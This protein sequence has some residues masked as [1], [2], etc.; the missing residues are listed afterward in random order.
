M[1]GGMPELLGAEDLPG[2]A[3]ALEADAIESRLRWIRRSLSQAQGLALRPVISRDPL[4]LATPLW[5]RLQRTQVGLG[6]GRIQQGWI[7]SED[8]R[9]ILLTAIPRFPASDRKR[10]ERMIQAVL[11]AAREVEA[12]FSASR[13]QVS[14]T[15]AHRMALD[16]AAM[17]RADTARIGVLAM[18]GVAALLL[19]VFRR[20]GLVGVALLPT[21]AGLFGGGVLLAWVGGEA[22]MVALGCG[23]CLVGITVDYAVHILYHVD[24]A[25]AADSHALAEVVSAQAF[26]ILAGAATTAAGFLVL[27]GSPMA[28]HRQLGLFAAAGVVV[29]ALFSVLILPLLLRPQGRRETPCTPVLARIMERCWAWLNQKPLVVMVFVVVATILAT[30]G[31]ARLRFSTDLGALNGITAATQRDETSIRE[32]WEEAIALTTVVV[33]ASDLDQA[34][35]HNERVHQAL[36]RLEATGQ[37]QSYSSSAPLLPSH[38]TRLRNRAAWESFWTPARTA[39]VEWSVR[40]AGDRLGFRSEVIGT[41]LEELL[42]PAEVTGET[43][44]SL[45]EFLRDYWVHGEEAW[46]LLTP[47]KAEGEAAF[48]ALHQGLHQAVPS[49]RLLNRAVLGDQMGRV[50]REGLVRYGLLVLLVNFGLLSLW[51]GKPRLAAITVLPIV[52][53]IFWTLGGMGL[54]GATL[55]L[56]N[57]LFIVF[58]AGVALDYSMFQVQARLETVRGRPDRVAAVGGAVTTCAATT[59]LAVGSLALAR[60]PALQSVGVTALLGIGATVAATGLLVPLCMGWLLARHQAAPVLTGSMVAKRRAVARRYEYQGAYVEQFVWWKLRLDPVFRFLEDVVP[61]NGRLLDLGCGFGI[62]GH[63]LTLGAPGRSVSGLDFD[64]FKI[65][66]ATASALGLDRLRFRVGDLLESEYPA[67]DHVLLLDVLHY[68]PDEGKSRVLARAWA[69]MRPGGTLVVREA[70]GEATR[71][72]RWVRRCESWAV[73]LGQNRTAHGLHFSSREGYE[74]L[75]RTAGFTHL[76]CRTEAGWGSNALLIARRG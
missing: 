3:A 44:D 12:R 20:K 41:W 42:V 63:W 36:E 54:I 34:L 53:G 6:A 74:T 18:G 46:H 10:S 15:G 71:A 69:A 60:H 33:S 73:Q 24:R 64:P 39:T 7:T 76:D 56:A 61:P 9:H 67:C 27:L 47:V 35:T 30:V 21:V 26:P 45:P 50:A 51:F 49:A 32:V 40:G 23:A 17:I 29:A 65:R 25:S 19:G 66:A 55:N 11:A 62:V 13:V 28:G 1:A 75:L 5:H 22:S 52:V 31:V 14:V 59:L 4:G 72:H 38:S 37:I 57:I 70:L 68:L 48:A 2:L 58:V 8:G 43:A 16:N